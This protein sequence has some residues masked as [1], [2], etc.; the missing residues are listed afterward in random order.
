MPA[1]AQTKFYSPEG[2]NWNRTRFEVFRSMCFSR[3]IKV[4]FIML[5][6]N[7]RAFGLNDRDR[8]EGSGRTKRIS[9]Q[10]VY[11][12]LPLST[13]AHPESRSFLC[14]WTHSNVGVL[15]CSTAWRYRRPP[16]PRA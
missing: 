2:D 8:N 15:I 14:S 13:I 12:L 11:M 9:P 7:P 5:T 1:G 16:Y 4:I 10:G 3:M 6:R